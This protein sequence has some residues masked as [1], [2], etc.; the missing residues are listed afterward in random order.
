LVVA[1][2]L[3]P[4]AAFFVVKMP[5]VQKWL[6]DEA[7]KVLSTK[8]GTEVSVGEVRFRPFNRFV[9]GDVYV[10][11]VAG[12]TLMFAE[13]M[14]ASLRYLS[15]VERHVDVGTLR[16]EG[17]QLNHM[18]QKY[19]P[20]DKITTKVPDDKKEINGENTMLIEIGRIEDLDVKAGL[21][22]VGN[23][24]TAY[25][26][27]LRQFCNEF[28]TYNNDIKKFWKEENWRE[29][30]IRLHAMKGVFASIGVDSISK[31]AYRLEAASRNGEYTVCRN[32]TEPICYSMYGFKE[33]LLATSL[34]KVEKKE[35]KPITKE[36]L[37]AKL[38][39]L[40]EVC[41]H[42]DTNKADGIAEELSVAKYSTAV[43][44]LIEELDN[45]LM[46]LD[47]D[48]AIGKI[49]EIQQAVI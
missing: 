46:S 36:D 2:V 43:D 35:K 32:E 49:E 17:A 28:D 47:Y 16:L 8:L 9:F 37:L 20:P 22:H 41:S 5:R 30:T 6:V 48:I 33:K 10:Q 45:M 40:K 12:D 25:L 4:T 24:L 44:A 42:G 1:L 38:E 39:A 13:A 15:F 11:G 14:S 18:L 31:W 23:N 29:Y 3:L 26:Q 19:L 34:M 7:T 21:S 27:I